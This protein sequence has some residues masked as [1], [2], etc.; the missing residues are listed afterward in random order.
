MMIL[1]VALGL[2]LSI[3]LI[4]SAIAY[5]L[6]GRHVLWVHQEAAPRSKK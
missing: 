5:L 3:M 1:V 2:F 6:F 4:S